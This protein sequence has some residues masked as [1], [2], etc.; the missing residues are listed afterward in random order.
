MSHVEQDCEDLGP[1]FRDMREDGKAR[2]ASNRER[3]VLILE[4]RGIEFTRFSESHL[5]V[6]DFDFWPGTGLFINRKTKRDGRGVFNLLKK[7][8]AK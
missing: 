2:R 5:R 7:L 6:G 8:G 4:E 1:T 3:S